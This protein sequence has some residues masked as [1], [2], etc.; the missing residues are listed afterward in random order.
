[1][2]LQTTLFCGFNSGISSSELLSLELEILDKDELSSP[3][4]GGGW[5]SLSS[6]FGRVESLS[7]DGEGVGILTVLSSYVLI[8]LASFLP[9]GG[10]LSCT[11]LVSPSLGV[12][13]V[14]SS[15]PPLPSLGSSF[16]LV[17]AILSLFHIPTV[18]SLSTGI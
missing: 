18:V 15:A 16:S 8:G 3:C 6:K 2:G 10:F 1:M 11:Q 17:I 5:V 13:L 14:S 12:P 9:S 4:P 7:S